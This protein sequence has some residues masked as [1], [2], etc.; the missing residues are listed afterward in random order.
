M[1][2][3]IQKCAENHIRAIHANTPVPA[4]CTADKRALRAVAI[5]RIG[6][7]CGALERG[8]IQSPSA[9]DCGFAGQYCAKSKKAGNGDF[10]AGEHGLSRDI[11]VTLIRDAWRGQVTNLS[12][13][14][15]GLIDNDGDM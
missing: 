12:N 11:Q 8:Q 5:E 15:G 3:Q 2:S 9:T 10:S 4:L 1:R 14:Y 6:A 7:D 13:Q